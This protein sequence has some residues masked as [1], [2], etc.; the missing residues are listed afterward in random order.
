MDI[1]R[2]RIPSVDLT[3]KLRSEYPFTVAQSLFRDGRADRVWRGE[4]FCDFC[5]GKTDVGIRLARV[6][7]VLRFG[8]RSRRASFVRAALSP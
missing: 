8:E 6:E 5:D 4:C 3:F 1:P 2:H 7:L